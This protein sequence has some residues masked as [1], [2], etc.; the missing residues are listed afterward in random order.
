MTH[1]F[2]SVRVFW[3]ALFDL[4]PYDDD[5]LWMR[6]IEEMRTV[7][8]AEWA[9]VAPP[10]VLERHI[11]IAEELGC[12]YRAISWHAYVTDKRRDKQ[13]SSNKPAQWLNLL[14][15]FRAIKHAFE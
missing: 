11:R 9:H 1:P 4:L 7:Y 15:E 10:D 5:Q 8:L 12:V 14:L 6:K 13:D 2:F 3:N